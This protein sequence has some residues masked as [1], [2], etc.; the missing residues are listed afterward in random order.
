MRPTDTSH[1]LIGRPP[2]LRWL[3]GRTFRRDKVSQRGFPHL[4]DSPRLGNRGVSPNCRSLIQIIMV[5]DKEDG[6][7]FNQS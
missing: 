6:S 3:S 4:G 5:G 1:L 2:K 7:F